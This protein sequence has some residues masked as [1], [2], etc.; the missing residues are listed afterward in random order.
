MAR[1]DRLG[2]A[3]KEIA[4]VGAAIGREFGHE[5]LASVADLPEPRLR[6]ALD[7]LTERRPVVRPRHAA[8][9]HL[10]L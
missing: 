6:D 4:Q 9:F 2:L 5:L 10:R 7:R 3:A 1:L 8:R